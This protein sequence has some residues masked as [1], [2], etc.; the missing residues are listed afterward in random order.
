MGFSLFYYGITIHWIYKLSHFVSDNK[1]EAYFFLTLA[2]LFITM[3]M[4]IFLFIP[5]ASFNKIRKYSAVDIISFSFLFVFGEWI[6][7]AFYPL[8]FPWARLGAIIT[9]FTAFIQSA[10]LLGSLFLSFLILLIN[11]FIAYALLKAS[12]RRS[13]IRYITV[14]AVIFSVN[15]IY[16][17]IR[18]Q[19][20]PDMKT[21]LN[22]CIIQ[23]NLSKMVKWKTSN[24]DTFSYYL[25]AAEKNIT[26]STNIVLL[27]ETALNFNILNDADKLLELLKFTKKH[28]ITLITGFIY[29]E[30]NKQYNSIM[31][32][33]PDGEISDI[34][35]KQI[36]VPIGETVP[37]PAIASIIL[38]DSAIDDSPFTKGD[39]YNVIKTGDT[40]YGGIICYESIFS[41]EARKAV[42]NGATVI[43]LPSNDSWFGT[44]T[45]LYQHH[46]HAILRAVENKRYVLR[47][48]NTAIS[49]VI[50][51]YG[52]IQASAPRYQLAAINTVFSP[53]KSRTLY[54]YAGD[55]IVLPGTA[56]FLIGIVK[57]KRNT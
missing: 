57:R 50:S 25:D 41:S 6:Q 17:A 49:S 2:L 47:A 8:A 24:D 53:V 48:S 12:K 56:M 5:L 45:A 15:T 27:P 51:P 4:G 13:P 9:P 20:S 14:A 28:N 3:L 54:S 37:F 38:P 40:C 18:L 43:V 1:Q 34:Y 22:A 55:I 32:I 52:V 19:N 10:S 44:S 46:A 42:K 16:G 36:L 29:T 33:S 35:S 31:A 23:G 7:E 21:S 26:P 11:G 39:Q 30:N